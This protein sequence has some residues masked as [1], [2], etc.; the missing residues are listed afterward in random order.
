MNADFICVDPDDPTRGLAFFRFDDGQ[1]VTWSMPLELALAWHETVQAADEGGGRRQ[2]KARIRRLQK[3]LDKASLRGQ[4][5][6]RAGW[7]DYFKE[8][9]G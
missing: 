1:P 9:S 7:P 3:R 8:I 4:V 2:R 6:E 5:T